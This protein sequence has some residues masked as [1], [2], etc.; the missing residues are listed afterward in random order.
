MEEQRESRTET[1]QKKRA[2]QG[3]VE[4]LT[5][6]LERVH[7]EAERRESRTRRLNG[8]TRTSAAEVASFDSFITSSEH[9]ALQSFL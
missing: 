8:S 9:K 1:A 3:G 2:L 6:S 4:R 5:C 7:L